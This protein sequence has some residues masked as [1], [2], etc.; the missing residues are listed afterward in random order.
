M[1]TAC[2]EETLIPE[3]HVMATDSSPAE[4]IAEAYERDWDEALAIA[5]QRDWDAALAEER[6]REWWEKN[7][8]WALKIHAAFEEYKVTAAKLEAD[9]HFQQITRE[10]TEVR[11]RLRLSKRKR[12]S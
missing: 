3:E 5:Y 4:V 12:A 10:W 2:A 8:A 9:P 6:N 7:K 1:T 11:K